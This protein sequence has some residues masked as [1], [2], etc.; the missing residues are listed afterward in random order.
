MSSMDICILGAGGHTRSILSLFDPELYEIHGIFDD[1]Y[2]SEVEESIMN[3]KVIGNYSDVP[4]DMKKVL[5]IGDN[6]KRKSLFM[7]FEDDILLNNLIHKTSVVEEN[8]ILGNSN[9]LL[10]NVYINS[11]AN[12]GSNNIINSGCIIEHETKIGSHNHISVGSILCGRVEVGDS[13]FIGA[14]SVIKDNVKIGSE[15][16]IGANS[17]VIHNITEPGTY[18]GNP[19]RIIK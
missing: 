6:K 10:A 18:V 2:T 12:I 1:S 8:V 4:S 13:C 9:Q 19:V 17:T 14:G 15:I 11:C 16:I 3:V 7:K 5:S